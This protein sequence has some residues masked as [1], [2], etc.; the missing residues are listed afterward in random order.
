MLDQDM[1]EDSGRLSLP[2]ADRHLTQSNL[3]WG[4]E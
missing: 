4:A 3:W 2:T 1:T